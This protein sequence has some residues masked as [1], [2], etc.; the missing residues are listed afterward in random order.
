[1]IFCIA[2]HKI[3]RWVH[4][5]INEG[6]TKDKIAQMLTF[7]SCYLI[8][9]VLQHFSQVN[10]GQIYHFWV[11]GVLIHRIILHQFETKKW[12]DYHIYKANSNRPVQLEEN[13]KYTN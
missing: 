6:Y 9:D 10:I 11:V 7:W 8:V 5:W 3:K 12:N 2:Y 13:K 4:N 1:M